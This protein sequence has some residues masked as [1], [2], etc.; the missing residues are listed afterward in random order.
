MTFRASDEGL[1][2]ETSLF[3]SLRWLIYIFKLFNI[4]KVFIVKRLL[5][6]SKQLKQIIQIE[7]NIVKNPNW[8]EAYQWAIYKCGR[9]FELGA[10]V[11]QFQLASGRSYL[12]TKGI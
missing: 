5:G 4:A 9:E 6:P 12:S 3:N 7:H 11:T 10:G 1:T 8:P 2:L